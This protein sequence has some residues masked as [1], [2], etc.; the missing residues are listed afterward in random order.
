VLAKGIQFLLLKTFYPI[1][2]LPKIKIKRHNSLLFVCN[3]LTR[4]FGFGYILVY[5]APSMKASSLHLVVCRR[6]V[7]FTCFVFVWYSGF[8]HI[9]VCYFVLFFF[10]LCTLCCQF[11]WIVYFRLPLRYSLTFIYR[12]AIMNSLNLKS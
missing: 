12:Q 4:F 6:V 7:L 9:F 3:L 2:K 8:Q 10:V 5:L 11:L 1:L